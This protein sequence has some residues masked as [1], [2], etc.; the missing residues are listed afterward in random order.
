VF[1]ALIFP[2]PFRF[3]REGE[4]FGAYPPVRS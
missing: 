1:D 3:S 4:P 2:I